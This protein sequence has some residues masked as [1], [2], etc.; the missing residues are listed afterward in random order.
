MPYFWNMKTHVV[1]FVFH[2][3][4]LYFFPN[5]CP[6]LCRHRPGHLLGKNKVAWNEKREKLHGFS[7]SKSMANFEAFCRSFCWAHKG[8][9]IHLMLV[10]PTYFFTRHYMRN[11]MHSKIHAKIHAKRYTRLK[12]KLNMKVTP[13]TL[14]SKSKSHEL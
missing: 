4:L 2:F 5:Y 13:D 11:C 6:G 14:S 12:A 3:V 9:L 7:Y 1:F 10:L 8:F